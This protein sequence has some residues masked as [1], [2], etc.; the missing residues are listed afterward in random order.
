MRE[1]MPPAHLTAEQLREWWSSALEQDGLS[2]KIPEL[3]DYERECP[4][5][6]DINPCT[7]SDT[8]SSCGE[9][10]KGARRLKDSH[11][12]DPSRY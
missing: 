6:L 8:C 5:C 2:G 7:G 10:L 4:H 11:R 1:H 3:S 9:S 12:F